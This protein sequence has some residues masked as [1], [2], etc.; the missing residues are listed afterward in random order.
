MI[1]MWL[2]LLFM[3]SATFAE[4]SCLSSR[5]NAQQLEAQIQDAPYRYATNE[6]PLFVSYR[7]TPSFS[8]YTAQSKQII[9]TRNPRGT[10]P[11]PI[12][13]PTTQWLIKHDQLTPPVTVSDLVAPFELEQPQ[14]KKVALLF[15]G[16]TDSPFSFHA[17]APLLWAQ[18]YTVRTLLLPGHATAPSD[19]QQVDVTAWSEITQEALLDAQT[20][21]EQVLL[22]GYSTGAALALTAAAVQPDKV[23]GIVL[24]A[25]ASQSH[26]KYSFLAQW[27]QYVPGL[28]WLDEA[29]DIDPFKYESFPMAAAALVH[30]VMSTFYQPNFN[31]AALR[32]IP[33]LTLLSE[34]DTTIDSHATL[35]LLAQWHHPRDTLLLYGER[36][37]AQSVLGEK[38]Q[39]EQARCIEEPCAAFNGMSHIGLLHPPSHPFYGKNGTYRHCG[40]YLNDL[41]K[42]AQCTL[43]PNAVR[44]ETT[45]ENTQSNPIFQRLTYNPYYH[46]LEQVLEHFVHAL[47]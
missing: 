29:P 3:S 41:Q 27:L 31:H 33:K 23:S 26:N 32:N 1:R 34:V 17:I 19:L 46:Q 35:G 40:I 42:Y 2:L 8:S 10:L 36:S 4:T 38:Y 25:P 22:V 30:E 47:P 16:L 9:A 39:I 21:F 13:T 45:I 28:R 11:C 12:S 20:N 44:G 15:H 18:G 7:S 43:E 37:W 5:L 14:S 6:G 24:I